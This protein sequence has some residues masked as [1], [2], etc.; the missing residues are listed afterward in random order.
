M[1]LT[2]LL[3]P[4]GY[5]GPGVGVYPVSVNPGGAVLYVDS[6]N[7]ANGRGRVSGLGGGA[8]V[9][10]PYGDPV[11]PLGSVFGTEGAASFCTAGRGDLIIVAPGHGEVV[12]AASSLPAGVTV[13][14]L[15]YGTVR[16]LFLLNTAITA[17]IAL[18]AGGRIQNCVI[19]GIGFDAITSLLTLAAGCQVLDCKILMADATNQAITGI[20]VGGADCL[21]ARCVIDSVAAAGAA[22]AIL[23]SAA[24]AGLTIESNYIEGNFSVANL[25]SASTNHITKMLVQNNTLYQ[26]NGTA[27]A[28]ISFTTSSTGVIRYNSF[29]G[30]TWA[31]ITDAIA[32]ASSVALKWSQNYGLDD[33]TV[34]S[35]ILIPAAGTVS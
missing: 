29:F 8:G 13:L 27:K 23:S 17:N 31:A 2:N 18:G 11:H 3:L 20:T 34:A 26:A 35:G 30:T 12:S 9:Q 32:G 7:G 16:P 25:V 1:P 15:G 4:G 6:T 33:V 10:G 14:G 5:T 28:V 21:I 22:Q 19:S 24:I